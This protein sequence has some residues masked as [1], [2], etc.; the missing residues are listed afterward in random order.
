MIL[1]PPVT[2]RNDPRCPYTT[3]FRSV[4]VRQG[5]VRIVVSAF[6]AAF[7][8]ERDDAV[9]RR[10]EVQRA[11]DHQRRDF[12]SRR[13]RAVLAFRKIT[14]VINQFRLEANDVVLVDRGQRR[15]AIAAGGI[16]DLRDRKR[17]RLETT[18]LMSLQY[19]VFS[20]TTQ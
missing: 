11:I 16:A 9:V 3:L 13:A 4:D 10:A 15:V 18:S 12:K 14:V 6:G 17:T 5:R 19:A 20:L 2:P 8:I 1:T 7:G